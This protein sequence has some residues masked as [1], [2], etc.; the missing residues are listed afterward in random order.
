MCVLCLARFQH[1]TFVQ[2]VVPCVFPVIESILKLGFLHIRQVAHQRFQVTRCTQLRI[3]FFFS[4][5]DTPHVELA[6]L[7]MVGL[8]LLEEALHA[9]QNDTT[10]HIPA[11]FYA[12][13]SILVILHLLMTDEVYVKRHS[14][15]FVQ[16][17]HYTAVASPVGGIEMYETA[18]GQWRL[19]PRLLDF[20][21]SP[22]YCGRAY[23]ISSRKLFNGL[24]VGHVSTPDLIVIDFCP[25]TKLMTTGFAYIKLHSVTNSIFFLYFRSACRTFFSIHFGQFSDFQLTANILFFFNYVMSHPAN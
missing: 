1:G 14:G 23:I 21:Q 2:S 17:K 16:G 20:A 19:L 5:D 13:N 3:F 11:C 8:K 22:L 24:F 9:V 6:H 12:G 7:D 18:S 4:L 25:F 15:R 10:D